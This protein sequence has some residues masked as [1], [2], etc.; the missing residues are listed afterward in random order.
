M[1]GQ[2]IIICLTHANVR[3]SMGKPCSACN[4][5]K[6]IFFTASH[7]RIDISTTSHLITHISATSHARIHIRYCKSQGCNDYH[8]STKLYWEKYHSFVAIGIATHAA[9][10][11]QYLTSQMHTSMQRGSIHPLSTKVNIDIIYRNGPGL[12]PPFLQT[13]NNQNLDSGKV[14][15]AGYVLSS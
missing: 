14:S 8:H 6:A 7:T 2:Y 10:L 15:E 1:Y 5:L 13:A 12:L 3:E 11:P 9:H 4:L